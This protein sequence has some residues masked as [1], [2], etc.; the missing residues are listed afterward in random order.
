MKKWL[1]RIL[2]SVILLVA[3][4]WVAGALLLRSWTAQP[5]PLPAQT[6]VLQLKTQSR[7]EKV[8]LGQSWVG[9]RE[10]LP[11]IYLKGEPFELGYAKGV[12]LQ[13]QI[14]TLENEFLQMIHGYV[15]HEW[16]LRLL[17]SYVIYRNRHLS[18]F[19]PLDYRMEMFG[20]ALGCPDIHPELGPYYNRILNYHAAHDIS[21][22]MID[23]PLVSHAGCTSF[24]AWGSTTTKGHLIT[25]RN[26]D[27]EA[28]EVFSRDRIVILCEPEHGIAFISLAWAGMAGVV[29]GMNRAGVSVTVNGAPSSL[30]REAATPVAI[31][32]REVLQRAHNLAEALEIV[33]RAKVFVS[34]VWLVGSRADGRFVVVEKT[35]EMTQVRQA[36]NDWIVCA[37]HFETSPMR[38]EPRN[39]SHLLEATSL[40]R[41]TRLT[42]LIR[43][44]Q[45]RIGPAEAANFLRDRNL[46]G[47]L[48][49]GNGHRA[50]LNAF[51]ATHATVMDLTDGIFWAASPPNQLGKFVA[52]DVQDFSREL[53]E[54]NVPADPVIA[55]GEYDRTREAQKCLAEGEQALRKKDPQTALGLA[56]KA[57][58]LNSGFYQ[59]ATLRGRALIA[60]EKRD[61]AK[62]SFQAALAARPAF[63]KE[64]KELEKLTK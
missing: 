53:P 61:E 45:G 64:K 40:S 25:G 42:E 12:L 37:N 22:M 13:P 15:P 62:H 3:A 2:L 34:T 58:L 9:R 54:N 26:F 63:L 38:D 48:F 56:D 28:A 6:R 33:G 47:G 41:Q 11:V 44:T 8:W 57:E 30:P 21:Y 19:V 24:G 7:E 14:H 16:T 23:N 36:E 20:A 5:P 17:K 46:P 10:G 51:I 31:L 55:S 43:Q 60:L 27:W 4:G 52:F 39:R 1:K 35:P 29:S 59:N 32:A 50:A 18:D 49:P